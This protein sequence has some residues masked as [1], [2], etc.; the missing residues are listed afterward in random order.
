MG[1]NEAKAYITH[2]ADRLAGVPSAAGRL[3][4][5]GVPRHSGLHAGGLLIQLSD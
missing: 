1:D 3:V 2:V 5:R 4:P